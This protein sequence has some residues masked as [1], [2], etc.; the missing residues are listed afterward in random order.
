MSKTFSAPC[1]AHARLFARS[2]HADDTAADPFW[3]HQPEAARGVFN[4]ALELAAANFK[5][6]GD[7]PRREGLALLADTRINATS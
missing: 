5:E 7:E 3:V 2:K 1:V 6:K 4:E